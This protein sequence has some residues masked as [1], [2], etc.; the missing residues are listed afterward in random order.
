MCS[1]HLHDITQGFKEDSDMSLELVKGR[2]YSCK[3]VCISFLSRDLLCLYR[4]HPT[5]VRIFSFFFVSPLGTGKVLLYSLCSASGRGVNRTSCESP[6][7][8][9]ISPG[10]VR[11]ESKGP[12]H[13]S[14]LLPCFFF[15]PSLLSV[16][17]SRVI[18]PHPQTHSC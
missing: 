15:F 11:K 8:T 1:F 6:V 10:V 13:I 9:I 5:L 12:R 2:L 14:S 7:Y 16:L 3:S 4:E 17:S 18:I